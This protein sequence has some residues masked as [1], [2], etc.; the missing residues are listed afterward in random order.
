MISKTTRATTS[1]HSGQKCFSHSLQYFLANLRLFEQNYGG[2][3]WSKC[4]LE[5]PVRGIQKEGR[6]NRELWGYA[7]P[8]TCVW[9]DYT[10]RF[11]C[12][13]CTCLFLSLSPSISPPLHTRENPCP[14]QPLHWGVLACPSS[15]QGQER[16]WEKLKYGKKN[17]LKSIQKIKK[18]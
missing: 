15:V 18:T 8:S 12:F 3:P 17:C 14:G 10:W 13:T 16:C 9:A 4:C 11:V 5:N 7:P 1:A 6:K 2:E